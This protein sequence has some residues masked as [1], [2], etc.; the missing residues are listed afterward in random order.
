MLLLLVLLGLALASPAQPN[1]EDPEFLAWLESDEFQE[2]LRQ[3]QASQEGSAAQG[4]TDG[5]P[6]AAEEGAGEASSFQHAL[7]DEVR[8][9]MEVLEEKVVEKAEDYAHNLLAGA[10]QTARRF[11]QENL[12]SGPKSQISMD[13]GR[14]WFNIKD[15]RDF[16]GNK[17][18]AE[19]FAKVKMREMKLTNEM[20][21]AV[22]KASQTAQEAQRLHTLMQTDPSV[23]GK[24]K[25]VA[26]QVEEYNKLA[27][28]KSAAIKSL[29]YP[30][31]PKIMT[32]W[33]RIKKTPIGKK[34]TNVAK[35]VDA[36]YQSFMKTPAGRYLAK[37]AAKPP[38]P[39]PKP[40]AFDKLVARWDRFTG[41]KVV[42]RTVE[43]KNGIRSVSIETRPSR[44]HML[45][46]PGQKLKWRAKLLRDSFYNGY[47]GGKRAAEMNKFAYKVGKV[48]WANGY[49]EPIAKAARATFKAGAAVKRG[50]RVVL[51][52]LGP[53]A[54]VAGGVHAVAE[55]TK[56]LTHLKDQA[57]RGE[58][59]D[60][61][62][63][64]N[65]IFAYTGLDVV[66]GRGGT[67]MIGGA[68][69]KGGKAFAKHLIGCANL[70]RSKECAERTVRAFKKTVGA[71]KAFGKKAGTWVKHSVAKAKTATKECMS[72]HG[73]AG[74]SGR[75]V[76]SAAKGIW[77]GGKW[78]VNGVGG[79]FKKH[80]N[81]HRERAAA[82]S[83][84]QAHCKKDE[85][86]AKCARED[87]E[88]AANKRKVYGKFARQTL[89]S[90]KAAPAKAWTAMKGWFKGDEKK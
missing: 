2:F 7:S 45:N 18:Y 15:I 10:G 8:H 50:A 58:D 75:A 59:L 68:V 47:G 70:K 38:P 88:V 65:V 39:P 12:L 17:K 28:A 37:A 64:R 48:A 24:F 23:A 16:T 67:E 13:G 78:V 29:K 69:I 85:H 42:K 76:A 1:L 49:T 5:S 9:E 87:A 83:A 79:F 31:P 26:A 34:A 32:Q 77:K 19:A 35:Y 41:P 30:T 22:N 43:V 55:A 80:W 66:L 33:D 14:S 54:M 53:V 90:I 82:K 81:H 52:K 51:G 84:R 71:V 20:L 63:V 57:A 21:A 60:P 27:K 6:G 36:R 25:T 56:D 46:Q 72:T 89:S 86:A 11:A 4:A 62:M 74:C 3:Y 44:L 40:N 61:K 73:V